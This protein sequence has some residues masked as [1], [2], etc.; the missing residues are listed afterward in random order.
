MGQQP[1]TLYPYGGS[2]LA[3]SSVLEAIYDGPIDSRSYSYQPVILEKLPSLADGDASISS[4]SVWAG[5]MVVDTDGN[6]TSLSNGVRVRPSGCRSSD[7]AITFTSGSL[8]M[9]QLFVFFSLIP[10]LQWSDGTPLTAYDSVYSFNLNHDPDTPTG[11]YLVERTQSYEAIDDLMVMW[12]GLPGYLDSTYYLNFWTPYPEHLWSRYSMTDLITEVDA[13]G[14]WLGWGPYIIDEW[15]RDE[16]IAL[17]RNPNYFRRSEGLP[18]FNY[19]VFRFLGT[20]ANGSLASLLAGECDILDQTS[21]MDSLASTLINLESSGQ[22]QAV[23]S[24]SNVYEHAD[25]NIRP[26]DFYRNAGGFA[27]WDQDG[28]GEGP[29]GDV[30]LRQAIAMCMDRQAVVDS[31]L[32]GQSIT[33]DSYISPGHPL[34]NPNN[35]HWPY[36]PAAAASL[37][38]EIGWLDTDNNPNTPRI[39]SNVTGVPN[40]TRLQFNYNTTTATLR[41]QTTQILAESASACGIQMDLGYY[42]ASEWFADGPD[43]ML[44]GRH[45]DLGEF[46]WITGVEPYCDLYTSTNIPGDPYEVDRN[47]NPLYPLGWGG[48]NNTGYSNPAFDEV[49]N[50]AMQSLPGESAYLANHLEAQ[51]ILSE[52]LPAIPLF[53]RIKLAVTRPD[54]CHFIMDPTVNSEMWNIEA[55]GW[56]SDCP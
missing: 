47:G 36:D 2:M 35:A 31:V 19:L 40:G 30:R 7:C 3:M 20:D 38:N 26:V 13:Q 41:Q 43:G 24:T 45:Y 8:E 9:D 22:L 33:I 16:Y 53:L 51:R 18:R 14:L 10:G 12:T 28:D 17:H 25:F 21:G 27:G 56:G 54:M 6:V 29:F 15:V 46:A 1:D 50:A 48:Q 55:F 44:F 34:Y 37:L 5:D 23:F 42:P 52:E 32:Y 49:C 39:A 11:T 4:V